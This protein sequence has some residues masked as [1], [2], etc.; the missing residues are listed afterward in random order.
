MSRI[1]FRLD[2][3][4]GGIKREEEKKK[5]R[6]DSNMAKTFLMCTSITEKFPKTGIE[7]IFVLRTIL[8]EYPKE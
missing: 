8:D 7:K 2:E 3:C 5:R 6:E 1:V 4:V